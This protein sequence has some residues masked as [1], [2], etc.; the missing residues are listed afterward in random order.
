MGR[1]SPAILVRDC[2]FQEDDWCGEFVRWRG[3]DDRSALPDGAALDVQNDARAEDIVPVFGR[4]AS[5]E[6]LS[7]RTWM[8][9]ASRWPP[10]AAAGL[11][12]PAS[13][14]RP[15]PRRSVRHGPAE[16][17]RRGGN[18]P[19]VGRTA[20]GRAVA[21]PRELAE[22]RLSGAAR[23]APAQWNTHQAK[24]SPPIPTVVRVAPTASGRDTRQGL[25]PPGT[26][27]GGGGTACPT[28]GAAIRWGHSLLRG[29]AQ[30][31]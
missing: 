7:R 30:G 21:V 26:R 13:R 8:V 16:R 14:G 11:P 24:L 23:P 9:E 17:L 25:S 3:E 12:R 1:G 20:A 10:P 28:T 18:R 5:L 6:S 19:G 27:V 4:V 31:A 2:G 22:A 29:A 15:H